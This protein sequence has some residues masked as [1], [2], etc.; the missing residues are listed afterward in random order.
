MA[1]SCWELYNW[2]ATG[3]ELNNNQ[4]MITGLIIGVSISVA[5]FIKQQQIVNSQKLIQK[6]RERIIDEK[7]EPVIRNI[8][9]NIEKI[10]NILNLQLINYLKIF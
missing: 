9:E 10:K 5:I 6:Q 7:I 4:T 1:G 2:L 3:C 8:L